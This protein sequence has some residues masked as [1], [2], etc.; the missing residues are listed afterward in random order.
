MVIKKRKIMS[1]D[2]YKILSVEKGA[3]ADEI[4]KAYRKKAMKLHP[5][6][7]KSNNAEAEFKELN[8]AYDVLKDEQKRSAYD[9]Y[10]KAAFEGGMGGGG[11]GRGGFSDF[12]FGTGGGAAGFSDIFEEMF[13]DMMGGRGGRGGG[14]RGGANRGS[15]LQY[16]L[17]ITLEEA[18]NGT[19]KS[20]RIPTWEG[21]ET[22]GG[23]GAKPGTSASTCK[24]CN[25]VGRVRAQQGFF[26][27]ERTC[28]SCNGAGEVIEEK[29]PSCA[30]QGRMRTS[31]TLKVNIPAGIEEGRRIRL[32]GEGE[33][34]LKGGPSG[35]L[36]VLIGIKSHKFYQREGANLFCRVPVAMTTAALGGEIKIPT[37]EGG[38]AEVKIPAGTQTGK[39]FR[40]KGKGMSI[41]Q[42]S[43]RGDAYIE[44][45]VETPVNLSSKQKDLLKEFAGKDPSKNSPESAGFFNKVKEFWDDLTE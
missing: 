42:S 3:S 39:Q 34:G 26:T 28:P 30:G 43:N 27:V 4:K 18:F 13:G 31:K 15:D 24:S 33:A 45:I 44:T 40:L 8:E 19:D 38:K 20:I 16:S 5:D 2:Y 6:T 17:D 36:Y 37:I 1:D 9:R 7:N 35:D 29:C 12:G 23:D 21:C 11:A 25:G 22:C 14:T 10:G 32:N 41:L